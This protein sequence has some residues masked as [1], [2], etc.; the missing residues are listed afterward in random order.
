[1]VDNP[2]EI[3]L[4]TVYT[5][6][7]Y[8]TPNKDKVFPGGM[9][10]PCLYVPTGKLSDVTKKLKGLSVLVLSG[11]YIDRNQFKNDDIDKLCSETA[12]ML[13]QVC[14][15]SNNPSP[16]GQAVFDIVVTGSMRGH[17]D[18]LSFDA[19]ISAK[20]CEKGVKC[21]HFKEAN[22]VF[23]YGDGCR[24]DHGTTYIIENK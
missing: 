3:E 12:D 10:Y 11:S 9:M 20:L 24:M 8:V 18:V 5:C 6:G 7:G 19:E 4:D 23:K 13:A 17:P 2:L 16:A 22:T 1:M 15:S 21:C 14:A